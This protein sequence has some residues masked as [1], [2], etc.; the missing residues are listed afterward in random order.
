MLGQAW[1]W[2]SPLCR[3]ILRPSVSVRRARICSLITARWI[4]M[5]RTIDTR[6]TSFGVS[7]MELRIARLGKKRSQRFW[8]HSYAGPIPN[9][10]GPLDLVTLA[11]S[12]DLARILKPFW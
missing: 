4:W 5:A 7:P 6:R 9:H 12:R 10:L 11:Q 3:G 8:L 2:P 1:A